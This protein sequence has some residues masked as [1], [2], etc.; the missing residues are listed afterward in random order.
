MNTH[1]AEASKSRIG[2]VEIAP[3]DEIG[4]VVYIDLLV[5]TQTHSI[6]CLTTNPPTNLPTKIKYV[7]YTEHQSF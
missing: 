5:L 4:I 6:R 3:A 2:F 7:K 1:Y